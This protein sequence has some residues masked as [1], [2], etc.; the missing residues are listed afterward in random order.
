MNL[1]I[2]L[3]QLILRPFEIF[4]IIGMHYFARERYNTIHHFFL[5]LLFLFH[6]SIVITTLS[7]SPFW[8]IIHSQLSW[9][10]ERAYTSMASIIM[11]FDSPDYTL[12]SGFSSRLAVW[13]EILKCVKCAAEKSKGKIVLI[14]EGVLIWTTEKHGYL[15]T[16]FGAMST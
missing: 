10:I 7:S 3:Q 16:P 11:W 4:N 2:C 14:W 15:T 5:T 1:K 9:I 6:Q 8:S 13:C 12:S